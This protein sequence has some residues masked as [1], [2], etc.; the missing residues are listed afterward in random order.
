MPLAVTLRL[1]S[2]S[3]DDVRRL[4]ATLAAQG[5]ADDV[6]RLDYA[7][8][9][10]LAV[11]PDAIGAA[12]LQAAVAGLAIPAL[13]VEI[14]GFGVFAGPPAVL[15]LAPVATAALLHWQA[16]LVAGLGAVDPHYRPGS[17]VPHVTL[18]Q[19]LPGLA[20]AGTAL[21]ALAACWRPIN[22]WLDRIEV[23]RF[24]PVEVLSSRELG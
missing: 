8:H 18:A 17:W 2:V 20:A 21:A 7:P 13:A 22:G 10:T 19:A 23:L 15:W 5:I 4:L 11:V 6:L 1:D 24:R 14:P 3:A 16:A 12:A 9:V